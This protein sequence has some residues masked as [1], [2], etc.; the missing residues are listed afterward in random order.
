M[1]FSLD[2]LNR[3]VNGSGA[4]HPPN[5]DVKALIDDIPDR[6]SFVGMAPVGR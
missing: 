6:V 1:A 2:E 3:H 4:D 5:V